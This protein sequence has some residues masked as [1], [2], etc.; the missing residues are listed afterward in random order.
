M[1]FMCQIIHFVMKYMSFPNNDSI[2]DKNNS[3][4]R[5]S[6]YEKI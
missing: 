2:Y 3:T 6:S 1:Y 4:I 5:Y